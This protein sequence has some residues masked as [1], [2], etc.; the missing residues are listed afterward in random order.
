MFVPLIPIYVA[1]VY[2]IDNF[3]CNSLSILIEDC[4]IW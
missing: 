2:K 4:E 1:K 3:G